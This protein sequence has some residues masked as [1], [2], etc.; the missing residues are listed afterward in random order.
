MQTIFEVDATLGTKVL[1]VIDTYIIISNSNWMVFATFHNSPQLGYSFCT[2][3]GSKRQKNFTSWYTVTFFVYIQKNSSTKYLD[4][5][6]WSIVEKWLG[7]VEKWM[8]AIIFVKLWSSSGLCNLQLIYTN[9]YFLGQPVTGRWLSRPQKTSTPR[10]PEQHQ[11][12][13]TQLF[14]ATSPTEMKLSPALRQVARNYCWFHVN[15]TPPER[16]LAS[17]EINYR[18][19]W[20]KISAIEGGV[21]WKIPSILYLFE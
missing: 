15:L 6:S 9:W 16:Y 4:H 3:Q 8:V 13:T 7:P 19:C 5:D 17:S 20:W 18:I 14:D 2:S 12:P 11:R 10:C 21:P 1:D